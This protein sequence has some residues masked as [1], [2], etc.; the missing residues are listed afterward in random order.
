MTAGL[1]SMTIAL[2]VSA[3]AG[4]AG[5]AEIK[6][7]A[8]IPV[9][10]EP[11]ASFDISFLDQASQRFFLADR[12]N[13]AVDVFDAKQN[14]FI[15]RVGGFVGAVVKDGRVDNA[16]SGPNGVLAFGDE[17]WAGDGDST[18]KV[19]DLKAM[20]IINTI[21]TGGKGRANENT[22]DPKDDIFIIGNQNEDP[23]FTTMV[24]T[25]AGHKIIGKVMMPDATDGNEQPMYN[26]ADGLVYQP[27][28]ILKHDAKKGGIAV[29]DPRTA[30]LL[31]TLEVD[32]CSPNGIA[33]GPNDNFALGCTANGI[34]MDK[35]PPII[36]IMNTKTGKLVA[37]VPDVG[38]SDEIAYSKKNNQYYIP[39][40]L[41]GSAVL[42]VID[43]ATNKLVQKIAFN[44]GGVSPHSVAVNDNDGHVFVPVGVADGG[45]G[46]IQVFGPQ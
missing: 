18:I 7:I 29:I 25:K 36:A 20:K 19:I 12:S 28:P 34:K 32:N 6:K 26:P 1:K 44:G 5:A 17:A 9:P 33:F 43:A 40:R 30:T 11:L 42:A 16:H 41:A 45:C 27:I 22:Y 23:P 4:T 10:G 2:A 21:S 38:G 8:E 46:C 13:K 14:K 3:L 37:N 24:S 39:S 35:A 31:K 15:G